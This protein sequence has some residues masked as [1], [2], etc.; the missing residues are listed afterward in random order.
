MPGLQ[1]AGDPEV[2]RFDLNEDIAANDG[3]VC[4][5]TME[6]LIDPIRESAEML[7]FVEEIL[8]AHEGKGDC[9][10]VT[11]VR[12]GSGT[13]SPGGGAA[14]KMFIRA[15]GS[16]DGTL[17][18]QDLD[19]AVIGMAL[20]QM[21]RGRERWFETEDGGN[22]YIETFTH[23]ATVVIAGGGH[24]GKAVHTLAKFL[25]FCTVIVDDRP[26]FANADRFPDADE[27]INADF[28]EGLR[29]LDMGPNHYAIIAT[30]GHKLD[31]VALQEAA[32]SRAGYVGLLGSKRKA[33]LIFRDLVRQGV[34]E[35][36]IR[37]IRAPVGLDLGGRGPE[38]IAMS[39]LAEILTA[40]YGQ[41]GAPMTM[42][43]DKVVNNI[44]QLASRR[45]KAGTGPTGR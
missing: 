30:R 37:E 29:S 16:A 2:R 41:N 25:G 32:R 42:M 18:S 5:G 12:P 1:L 22:V 3:L 20:E 33:V 45:P 7:S 31:D 34:P 13:G 4:G 8:E 44:R 27:I 11:G 35:D 23:P 26:K 15:D 39:I 43:D 21:P 28:A 14:R 9:A 10:L 6:I 24:V 19:D 36:R 40:K 38:E 17:G